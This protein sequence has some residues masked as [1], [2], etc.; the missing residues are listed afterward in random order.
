MVLSG[1]MIPSREL[2]CD[3]NQMHKYNFGFIYFY[4][5]SQRSTFFLEFGFADFEQ[6]FAAEKC[7]EIVKL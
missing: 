3:S 2:V 1:L 4:P 6:P 7:G 5:E